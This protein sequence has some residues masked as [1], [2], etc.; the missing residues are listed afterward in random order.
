MTTLTVSAAARLCGVERRTLLTTQRS[1]A[2]VT[3]GIVRQGGYYEVVVVTAGGQYVPVDT[4]IYRTA[5]AAQQR[6]L[7]EMH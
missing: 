4:T 3:Y 6:L 7:G 1:A 2:G 5:A